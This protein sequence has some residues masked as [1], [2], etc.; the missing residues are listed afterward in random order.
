MKHLIPVS[1]HGS[2]YECVVETNQHIVDVTR[3]MEDSGMR[4]KVMFK[5]LPESV[6]QLLIHAI[7]ETEYE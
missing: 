3:V 6:Q 7:N 4:S 1:Y 2:R 5:E